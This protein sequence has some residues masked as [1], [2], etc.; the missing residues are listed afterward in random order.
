MLTLNMSHI[1]KYQWR[2]V[3]FLNSYYFIQSNNS[4]LLVF[5]PA[6]LYR[7]SSSETPA[8]RVV[9]LFFRL[10]FQIFRYYLQGPIKAV[11]HAQESI[12]S[13]TSLLPSEHRALRV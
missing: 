8:D 9:L 3:Y 4:S 1:F 5:M 10:L 12:R 6:P 2:I 13:A 11:L 7:R